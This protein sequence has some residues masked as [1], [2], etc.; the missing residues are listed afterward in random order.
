MLASLNTLYMNSLF[1]E[2]V[3]A[4]ETVIVP[5]TRMDVDVID[6][7]NVLPKEKT[8]DEKKSQRRSSSI[9]ISLQLD[10]NT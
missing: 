9:G 7:E 1:S 4:V 3:V 5:R 8:E 10:M 2:I 6:L